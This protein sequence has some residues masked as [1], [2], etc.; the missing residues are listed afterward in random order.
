[1]PDV[2]RSTRTRIVIADDQPL[3]LEGLRR[4]LGAEPDME[5][6]GEATDTKMAVALSETL[7][8]DLL[9]LDVSLSGKNGVDALRQLSQ[10]TPRT[11]VLLMSA[12]IGGRD[13]RD[14][15]RHGARGQ[16]LKTSATDLILKAIR[17]VAA[18]DF[19][20]SRDLV[21]ELAR[22]F[23]DTKPASMLSAGRRARLTAREREVAHL[24]ADGMGNKE[25]AARLSVSEDTVK[26]HL[27]SAFNKTGVSSRVELALRVRKGSLDAPTRK[28]PRVPS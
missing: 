27:T 4:V 14:A 6:V 2:T 26:H 3:L 15:L 22:A 21:S 7:S 8:P 28:L 18:G 10:V 9:L 24:L 1:M 13:L 16:V 12:S 19:W 20:I 5:V 11:R 25:I 23:A 17:V